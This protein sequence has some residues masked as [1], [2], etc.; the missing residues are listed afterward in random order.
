M[1]IKTEGIKISLDIRGSKVN[2]NVL[3]VVSQSLFVIVVVLKAFS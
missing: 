2:S 1:E 3:P